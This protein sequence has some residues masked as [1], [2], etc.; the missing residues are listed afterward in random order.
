MT[1]AKVVA[2][3]VQN[4]VLAVVGTRERPVWNLHFRGLHVEHVDWLLPPYGYF[5]DFGCL[6]LTSDAGK[7]PI[8]FLPINAAV[9]FRHARACNFTDGGV[10]H[11]G[12]IGLAAIVGLRRNVIEGNDIHDIGGGAIFAGGIRN[13]H[14]YQWAEPGTRTI[15]RDTA[16]PT[17]TSTTAAPTT[18]GLSAY[19][20]TISKTPSWLTT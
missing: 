11:V 7:P 12:G 19:S 15:S 5:A 8:R 16:S 13:R 10:A 14:T 9:S 2:P 1:R 17:I 4:T 18:S 20:S 3:L 6:E